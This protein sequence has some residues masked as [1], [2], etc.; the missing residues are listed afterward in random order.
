MS[1]EDSCVN[2]AVKGAMVKV[3]EA[4]AAAD[5]KSGK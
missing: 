5:K 4:V 1:D 2:A 3:Q